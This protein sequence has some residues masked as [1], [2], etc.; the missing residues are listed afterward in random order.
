GDG[1]GVRDMNHDMIAAGH[2]RL[3]FEFAGYF[4]QLPPHWNEVVR[5]R[6]SAFFARAWAIGQLVSA[7]AALGLLQYR[8][9]QPAWPELAEFACYACH[10]GL[11]GP[12]GWR[13]DS[14][15]VLQWGSWYFAALPALVPDIADP[16]KQFA[17]IMSQRPSGAKVMNAVK[18]LQPLLENA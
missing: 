1:I 12:A 8:A 14:R 7:E 4:A 3:N 11:A 9:Q 6:D 13:K 18:P 2:P 10:H 16:I 17:E 15:G 5:P